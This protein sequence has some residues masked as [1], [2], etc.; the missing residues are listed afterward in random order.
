MRFGILICGGVLPIHNKSASASKPLSLRAMIAITVILLACLGCG[1]YLTQ[2]GLQ[3]VEAA[4]ESKSW[5]TTD[6]VI[7]RSSVRVFVSR[8]AEKGRVVPS[9]ESRSCSPDIEYRQESIYVWLSRTVSVR[10]KLM[11]PACQ[12]W[13][14]FHFGPSNKSPT[15]LKSAFLPF[16]S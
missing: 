10:I 2:R 7:T 15:R 6:G 9:R 14:D 4:L 1:V 3:S 11:L 8:H 13:S 16:K 12:M 5:P